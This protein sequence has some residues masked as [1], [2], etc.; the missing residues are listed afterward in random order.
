MRMETEIYTFDEKKSM[1]EVMLEKKQA[2]D[3]SVELE[4][5][6]G[7]NVQNID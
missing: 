7:E 4:K 6:I 3:E 2:E 1:Y 5:M